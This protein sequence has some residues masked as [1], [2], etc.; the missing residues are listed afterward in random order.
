MPKQTN[1]NQLLSKSEAELYAELWQGM[2][3]VAGDDRHLTH[4]ITDAL[5]NHLKVERSSAT[6]TGG[7]P[8]TAPEETVEIG[9]SQLEE[10]KEKTTSPKFENLGRSFFKSLRPRIENQLCQEWGACEKMKADKYVD[11]GQLS[12]VICDVLAASFSSIPVAT[13]SVLIVKIGVKRFCK[14][15]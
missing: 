14:C 12:A 1:F 8:E 7:E 3:E 4:S 11:E 2:R 9:R 6:D 13:V 10:N 5:I 15:E